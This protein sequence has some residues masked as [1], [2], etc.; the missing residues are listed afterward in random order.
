[1]PN[2]MNLGGETQ[3]S[4]V[5][6]SDDMFALHGLAVIRVHDNQGESQEMTL[7][8][9][10]DSDEHLKFTKGTLLYSFLVTFGRQ[11]IPVFERTL[12]AKFKMSDEEIQSKV[13]AIVPVLSSTATSRYNAAVKATTP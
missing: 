3:M 1:M 13:A 12:R 5:R 4:N 9:I 7:S 11:A 10:A 6:L 8:H 2:A